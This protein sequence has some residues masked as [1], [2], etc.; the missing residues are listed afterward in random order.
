VELSPKGQLAEMFGLAGLCS[1]AS[2]LI[3]PLLWGLVVWD[4]SR[5]RHAVVMLIGLLAIGIWLLRRV[6]Y[7][8]PEAAR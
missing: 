2:T 8:P 5:Y 3:G 4:P 7:P 6:P 1:R